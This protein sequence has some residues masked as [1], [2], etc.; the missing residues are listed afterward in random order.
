MKITK[1]AR[2]FESF[3]SSYNIEILNFFNP[4]LKLRDTESSIKNKLKKLPIELRG[5]K[6]VTKLVIVFKKIESKDKTKY[7]TFYSSSKAE[8]VINDSDIDNVFQSIYTTIISNIQ[9]SLEKGS[10]WFIDSVIDYTIVVYN[11]GLSGHFEVLRHVG[12]KNYAWKFIKI[13]QLY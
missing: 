6:F 1:Q 13:S 11:W 4:K 8:I 2:A 5:F 3:A 12:Q 10:G 9:K 7:D